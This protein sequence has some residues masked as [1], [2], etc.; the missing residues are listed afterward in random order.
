MVTFRRGRRDH[1]EL[2]FGSLLN[3][4]LTVY[5]SRLRMLLRPL[6]TRL[7]HTLL[8]LSGPEYVFLSLQSSSQL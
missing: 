4:G 2:V 1:G 6:P 8:M 7:Q 5:V 3:F